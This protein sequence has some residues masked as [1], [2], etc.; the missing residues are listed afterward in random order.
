MLS[1]DGP[2]PVLA[3]LNAASGAWSCT[4]D[5]SLQPGVLD[6][7][8]W[9]VRSL[10]APYLV[11]SATA[12]GNVVSGASTGGLPAGGPAVMGYAPPPFDVVNAIAQP[13]FAFSGFPVVV[14]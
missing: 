6:E 10:L 11:T 3:T 8:N 7:G 12:A 5:Q 1:S 4:F 9:T 14:T 13:T 2:V